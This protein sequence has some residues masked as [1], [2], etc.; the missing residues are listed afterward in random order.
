LSS[1]DAGR[2]KIEL[3]ERITL[4]AGTPMLQARRAAW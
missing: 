3:R 2:F 4:F 1:P